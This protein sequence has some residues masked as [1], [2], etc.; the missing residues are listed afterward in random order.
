MKVKRKKDENETRKDQS[1][2]ENESKNFASDLS[3]L[4]GTH[5]HYLCGA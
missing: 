2:K 3:N 4:I 1:E 5:W